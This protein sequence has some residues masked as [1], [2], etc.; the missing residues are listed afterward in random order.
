MK[1]YGERTEHGEV[2]SHPEV[3]DEGDELARRFTIRASARE[4]LEE[5]AAS[6]AIRRAAAT[7]SRPMKRSTPVPSVSFRTLPRQTSGNGNAR[8]ISGTRG[9]DWTSRS[10]LLVWWKGILVRC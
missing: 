3:L 2:V 6:E 10:K 9:F 7:R 4:A 8:T 1:V 5:H